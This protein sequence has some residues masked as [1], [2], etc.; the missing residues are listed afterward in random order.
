MEALLG[1]RERQDRAP[2][3]AAIAARGRA[4]VR[5]TPVTPGDQCADEAAVPGLPQGRCELNA[6]P[7]GAAVAGCST[8]YLSLRQHAATG[9]T[10]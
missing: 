3:T 8:S 5:D 2:L 7:W 1:L 10:P 4:E 9:N 6:W